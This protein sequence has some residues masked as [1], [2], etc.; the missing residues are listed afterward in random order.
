MSFL[1]AFLGPAGRIDRGTFWL[2]AVALYLASF[3]VALVVAIPILMIFGS[4][5]RAAALASAVNGAVIV[6]ALL[7]PACSVVQLRG[8]ALALA[9][10][11]SP[12]CRRRRAPI[13]AQWR[14]TPPPPGRLLHRQQHAEDG[15]LG[16]GLAFDDA[17]VV[18]DD[19]GDQGE[20]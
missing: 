12:R 4:Q 19:L 15:A 7:F 18:S 3:V 9:G 20:A 8:G 2:A 16:L 6:A 14:S 17:A 10:T 5:P 1:D 11:A 13:G